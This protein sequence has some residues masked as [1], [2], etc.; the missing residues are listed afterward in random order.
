MSTVD[1]EKE[2]IKKSAKAREESAAMGSGRVLN[3][4]DVE[5]VADKTDYTEAVDAATGLADEADVPRDPPPRR[6]EPRT[7]TPSSPQPRQPAPAPREPRPLVNSVIVS[8]KDFEVKKKSFLNPDVENGF[9]DTLDKK[10]KEALSGNTAD[11]VGQNMAFAALTFLFDA[12]G[13][14]AV[15]HR[16]E[17]KRLKKEYEDRTKAFDDVLKNTL[18]EK[19]GAIAE[20]AIKHGI[21]IRT[22]E[23]RE[24]LEK[25]E[26]NKEFL[27]LTAGALSTSLQREVTPEETRKLVKGTRMALSKGNLALDSQAVA[28]ALGTQEAQDN[29]AYWDRRA[30]GQRTAVK[31]IALF[32]SAIA[33]ARANSDN[34][35]KTQEAIRSSVLDR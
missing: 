3:P 9:W 20:F 33:S 19:Y 11:E 15:H 7:D 13:N 16:K 12:I 2:G 32:R 21:D 34:A 35:G 30:K 31:N 17:A 14:W 25:L 18:V 27:G 5:A 4:E 8:A 10:I 23:G 22:K 28:D 1:T 26:G 24:K 29:A 6:E